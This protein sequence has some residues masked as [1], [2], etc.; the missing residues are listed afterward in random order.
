MGDVE[1][2]I[3]SSISTARCTVYMFDGAVVLLP[4]DR[5]DDL[6]AV[7]WDVGEKWKVKFHTT[8]FPVD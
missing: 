5:L 1:D 7:L 2:A 3:R 6:T 4:I 8:T